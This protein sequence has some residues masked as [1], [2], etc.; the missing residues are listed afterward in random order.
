MH[1]NRIIGQWLIVAGLALLGA[2]GAVLY[3]NWDAGL[4]IAIRLG[5]SGI[6]MVTLLGGWR[7]VF[8]IAPETPRHVRRLARTW[9]SRLPTRPAQPRDRAQG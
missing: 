4:A 6:L 2:L 8:C 3:S 1:N 7:L 5:I 9:G